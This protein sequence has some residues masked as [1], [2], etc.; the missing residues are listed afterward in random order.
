M[1]SSYYLMSHR[2]HSVTEEDWFCVGWKY[3]RIKWSQEESTGAMVQKQFIILV[4][5][6][7]YFMFLKH[8]FS[9]SLNC[10]FFPRWVKLGY[11][12]QV[13]IKAWRK[14]GN[15][16]DIWEK[17]EENLSFF[18]RCSFLHSLERIISF[19]TRVCFVTGLTC[20][21]GAIS[22]KTKLFKC[23]TLVTGTKL[24]VNKSLLMQ[25]NKSVS[26]ITKIKIL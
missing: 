13:D 23:S 21:N 7:S 5:L 26:R 24:V 19:K 12:T 18:L 9:R 14:N 25:Q 15:V 2:I 10:L 16:Q 20:L 17:E 8:I 11:N 4:A 3:M 6:Y 22:L 1:V